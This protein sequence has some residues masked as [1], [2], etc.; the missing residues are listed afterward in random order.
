M[1]ARLQQGGG[2]LPERVQRAHRW[3]VEAALDGNLRAIQ[4]LEIGDVA[5]ADAA[6][7]IRGKQLERSFN[8]GAEWQRQGAVVHERAALEEKRS[9]ARHG[10]SAAAWNCKAAEEW[11]FC[12]NV[13]LVSFSSVLG[14]APCEV[15]QSLTQRPKRVP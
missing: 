15:D 11:H 7:F 2:G 8:E 3:V 12:A 5:H 10:G 6:H 13:I 1:P 9:R 4:R 14:M